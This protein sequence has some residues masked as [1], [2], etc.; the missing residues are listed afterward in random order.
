MKFL[1][2][3]NA[4]SEPTHPRPDAGYVAWF[5]GVGDSNDPLDDVLNVS[6]LTIAE[7]R[8]GVSRLGSGRRRSELEVAIELLVNEYGPRILAVD[9]AV[10][11]VWSEIAE[12]NRRKG[13]IVG[14]IDELIAATAIAHDLTLVTRNVGHF[15]STGCKLLCPWS[16]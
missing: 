6:V 2:D 5:M 9:L 14:A 16:D 3:T 13:V 1:L 4:V 7:L 12:N 15:N 11:E 10:A 8:R